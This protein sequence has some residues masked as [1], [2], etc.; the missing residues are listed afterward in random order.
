MGLGRMYVEIKDR[1][2]R[3]PALC[4]RPILRIEEPGVSYQS[5]MVFSGFVSIRWWSMLS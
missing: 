3:D 2:P 1:A 4:I 5:V